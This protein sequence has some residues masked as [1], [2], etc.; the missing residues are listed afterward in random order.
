M[1]ALECL[2]AVCDTMAV[3]H[4]PLESLAVSV[5]EHNKNGNLPLSSRDN[6][7]DPFT[8]NIGSDFFVL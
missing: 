8:A 4:E 3:H 6:P 2:L 1:E 5:R 7:E